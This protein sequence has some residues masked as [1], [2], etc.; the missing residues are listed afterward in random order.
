MFIP[1]F[2]WPLAA[3][4]V[5]VADAVPKLNVTPSCKGAAEAGYI[6]TTEGRL[7]S[8]LDSEMRTRDQLDKSWASFP[9]GDRTF[10]MSSI[11]SF[12]PTYTEL[13]TC[14]E[15]KRDLAKMKPGTADTVPMRQPR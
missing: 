4:L 12:Q 2:A 11:A 15:M 9:I 3:Q 10:C 14:L 1:L 6:A 8:C 5:V 13:A 7:K